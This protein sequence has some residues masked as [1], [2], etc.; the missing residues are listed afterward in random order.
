ML[1][2]VCLNKPKVASSGFRGRYTFRDKL[3][4]NLALFTLHHLTQQFLPNAAM[5]AV[6]NTL[7]GHF[8]S[9]TLLVP[10]GTSFVSSPNSA[11]SPVTFDINNAFSFKKKSV[12]LHVFFRWNSRSWAANCSMLY[13]WFE[14]IITLILCRQER[15]PILSVRLPP[16]TSPVPSRHAYHDNLLA[17]WLC[18][19]VHVRVCV[20]GCGII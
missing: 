6:L 15:H 10:A 11:H 3:L 8:I 2:S 1:S 9:Y 4:I 13:V 12:S 20:C 14:Y 19:C 16:L 5:A 7:T 18:V 17:S